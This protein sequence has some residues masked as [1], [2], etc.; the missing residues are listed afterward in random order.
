M[1]FFL[2]LRLNFHF[3]D[4]SMGEGSYRPAANCSKCLCADITFRTQNRSCSEAQF[5]NANFKLNHQ[6][7]AAQRTNGLQQCRFIQSKQRRVFAER[8]NARCLHECQLWVLLSS[9]P[10]YPA[11]C[12]ALQRRRRPR[13]RGQAAGGGDGGGEEESQRRAIFLP[14]SP[15]GIASRAF[16]SGCHD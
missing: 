3:S 15:A 13:R 10:G 6:S 2:F 7:T 4:Y 5:W 8:K 14:S 9:G 16:H 12:S 1:L 11:G